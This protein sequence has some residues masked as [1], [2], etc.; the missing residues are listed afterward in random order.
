MF[1]KAYKDNIFI[2]RC[3]KIFQNIHNY[4]LFFQQPFTNTNFYVIIKIIYRY[5]FIN[6]F[7]GGD[8]K[9]SIISNATTDDFLEDFISKKIA[10]FGYITN[11]NT[12][13]LTYV[14]EALLKRL[15]LNYDDCI[16]KKCYEVINKSNSPCDICSHD[17]LLY[18]NSHKSYYTNP[19]TGGHYLIKDSTFD[20]DG[21]AYLLHTAHDITDEI[22]EINS[23]KD[24]IYI[25]D[26]IIECAKTLVFENDFNISITNL[27]GIICSF[28]NADFSFVYERNYYKNTNSLAYTYFRKTCNFDYQDFDILP[29][30]SSNSILENMLQS[31]PYVFVSKDDEIVKKLGYIA[32][33]LSLDSN[34]NILLVPLKIDRLIVGVIGVI[35]VRHHSDDFELMTNVATFV[36]SKLNTKYSRDKLKK[37]VQKDHNNMNINNLIINSAKTLINN[38]CDID[39]DI[40]INKLL[41]IICDFFFAKGAFIF[42]RDNT[43][44][45]L[46]SRY[47]YLNHSHLS[48][49]SQWSEISYD[50]ILEWFK[51]HEKND[52]LYIKSVINQLNDNS[53]EYKQLCIDQITS[54]MLT[55][56]MKN[57]EIIGFLWI[58]N[59]KKNTDNIQVIKTISTLIVSHIS[60]DDLIK[61]LGNLSYSDSLTGLYNRNFYM[62]YV[63]QLHLQPRNNI[64]VIFADINGLKQTNDN[65]GHEFGDIL[66]Q[67]SGKFLKR[68]LRGFVFR[69]G[70]DEF[71]SFIENIEES[72]FYDLIDNVKSHLLKYQNIHISIGCK[73]NQYA[74]DI[75]QLVKEADDIMY[76]EKELYYLEKAK[77]NLS[78]EDELKLVEEFIF[79]AKDSLQQN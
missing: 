33:F 32:S 44:N 3:Y 28:G 58:D 76:K 1:K 60:K 34:D 41:K 31:N 56:L 42:N 62:K 10:G 59:P 73:W 43:K 45:T 63:K 40:S 66:V 24:K 54:F 25:D 21:N 74:N 77:R 27:L 23:L 14:N 5:L 8:F 53:R 11:F 48:F 26:A 46:Y 22:I 30:N 72:E 51:L 7:S 71:V 68:H 6:I 9:L 47:E 4:C 2:V 50:V 52:C 69:I 78:L 15:N 35:N 20:Y 19:I 64:G 55:P 17:K 61:Q 75:D 49:N 18:K 16:G 39:V 65:L 29:I 12:Y 36:V 79:Q 37:S 13:E 70:G 57:G 38:D 67:W